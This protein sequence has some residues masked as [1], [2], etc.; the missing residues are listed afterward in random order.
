MVLKGD[1]PEASRLYFSKS[2]GMSYLGHIRFLGNGAMGPDLPL[3][4]NGESGSFEVSVEDASSL[5]VGQDILIGWVITDA[6]VA[7]HDMTGTWQA[8]NGTWQPF[9]QREVVGIDTDV[10]P[11][12]V[13]V[14]VPLR[15]A[16]LMSDSA[17]I[18]V[19]DGLLS[20]CG[21]EGLGLSNAVAWSAAWAKIRSMC[22]PWS[23]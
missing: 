9:F 23:L 15:Y 21:V 17:S 3:V 12:R 22:F 16:S 10:T 13:Q 8:F 19:Q 18:R 1:G 20:E 5:Q 7:A 6:F 4:E 11:H 2:E 14:D